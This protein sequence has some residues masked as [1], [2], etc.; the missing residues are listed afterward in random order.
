MTGAALKE[1]APTFTPLGALGA[2]S[3]PAGSQSEVRG[4]S[5]RRGTGLLRAPCQS[6]L[7][8]GAGHLENLPEGKLG[9]GGACPPQAAAHPQKPGR[10]PTCGHQGQVLRGGAVACGTPA[11][12]GRGCPFPC[13]A[14]AGTRPSGAPVLGDTWPLGPGSGES[15][16]GGEQWAAVY[17]ASQGPGVLRGSAAL[18][19]APGGG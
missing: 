12:W 6:P 4:G 3:G 15:G 7:L 18:G 5:L 10:P 2:R 11:L 1:G 14:A 13:A 16:C 19:G 9:R 8:Q 17:T